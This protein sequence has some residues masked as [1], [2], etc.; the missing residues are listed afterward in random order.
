MRR[1]EVQKV[2]TSR[3]WLAEIDPALAAAVVQ[4]GRTLSLRKGE[5]LYNPEDNPGG[6][7]GVITGGHADGDPGTRRPALAGAYRATLPLVRLWLCPGK[8]AAQHDHV[9]Q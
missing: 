7:F 9:G 8:A 1:S 3:G 4:S 6:M 2:L 5:L